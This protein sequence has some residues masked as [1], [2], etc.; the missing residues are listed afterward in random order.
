MAFFMIS[1]CVLAGIDSREGRILEYDIKL[2]KSLNPW[3]VSAAVGSDR[4]PIIHPSS[5]MHATVA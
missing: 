2:L 1:F 4:S 5:T 3:R